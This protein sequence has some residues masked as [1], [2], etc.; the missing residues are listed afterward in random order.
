MRKHFMFLQ[1]SIVLKL[2]LIAD[3]HAG[4]SIDIEIDDFVATLSGTW[5]FDSINNRDDRVEG[6]GGYGHT[7]CPDTIRVSREWDRG[8]LEYIGAENLV[9]VEQP[10]SPGQYRAVDFGLFFNINRGRDC[11]R[12]ST[13]HYFEACHKTTLSDRGLVHEVKAQSKILGFPDGEGWSIMRQKLFLHNE[14]LIIIREI[15]TLME[16]ND[17]QFTSI[18]CIY[19]RL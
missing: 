7:I 15:D 6:G 18:S 14:K 16:D 1:L 4:S 5:T 19:K 17:I 9:V 8:V 2:L 10:A 12:D 11:R 13:L 3:S